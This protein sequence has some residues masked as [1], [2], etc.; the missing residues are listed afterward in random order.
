MSLP[1]PQSS[2]VST[3][4]FTI[5]QSP[6]RAAAAA[7]APAAAKPAK[8]AAEAAA[9]AETA[10][11]RS[12]PAV[13]AAPRSGTPSAA[14]P[15]AR[16]AGDRI[17]HHEQNEDRHDDRKARL[18]V[19]RRAFGGWRYSLQRDVA[20]F[21]NPADD[22]RHAGEQARAIVASAELR[23]HLFPADLAG[24]AV[25]DEFL[26]VVSDLHPDFPVLDGEQNEQPVVLALLADAAAA[27]LEHLHRVLV[28]VGVRGKGVDGGDDHHVAAC[29]LQGPDERVHGGCAL[30]IDDAGE[31]VDRP[32]Q[33]GGE[34]L[35]LCASRTRCNHEEHEDDQATKNTKVTKA[36]S[37]ESAFDGPPEAATR[38][39]RPRHKP[40]MCRRGGICDVAS[41]RACV[42]LLRRPTGR[43]PLCVLRVLCGRNRLCGLCGHRRR[44]YRHASTARASCSTAVRY[45][46]KSFAGSVVGTVALCSSAIT[47]A[48]M[49]SGMPATPAPWRVADSRPAS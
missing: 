36:E 26:E 5:H 45:S 37:R 39:T 4:R 10:A 48:M 2:T 9:P 3:K 15:P 29:L 13:P 46:G 21:G 17:D 32:C 6:G 33:L 38:G 19:T 14:A 24:E 28:D 11:E 49:F 25:G 44:Q 1:L 35:L 18:F 31:V 27:V 40:A 34:L 8:P 16:A 22:A 41:A 43:P 42:G 47:S 20:S 12:D 30:R 23:R 7:T